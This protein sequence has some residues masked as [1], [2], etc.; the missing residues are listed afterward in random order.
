MRE[1]LIPT[2]ENYF[3]ELLN[4]LDENGYTFV[5]RE[6]LSEGGRLVFAEVKRDGEHFE[7][8]AKVRED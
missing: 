5:T 7:I 4:V 8:R 1:P 6:W 2:P 3:D